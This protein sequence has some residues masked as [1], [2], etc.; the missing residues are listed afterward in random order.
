MAVIELAADGDIIL[1][2]QKTDFYNDRR[3]MRDPVKLRVSSSKLSFA[4]NVFRDKLQSITSN[5]RQL[6]SSS[7]TEVQIVSKH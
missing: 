6:S 5:G 7:P 1:V 4:S 3:W 2:V